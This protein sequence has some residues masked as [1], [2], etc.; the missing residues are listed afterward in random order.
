[1]DSKTEEKK[2]GEIDRKMGSFSIN[3]S[4]DVSLTVKYRVPAIRS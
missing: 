3:M 2:S 1:M 4:F